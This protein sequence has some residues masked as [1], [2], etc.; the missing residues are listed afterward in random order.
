MN[1]VTMFPEAQ[2]IHLTKDVGMI[3]YI[4][5]K[6]YNYNST[7]VCYK[8]EET[9]NY[10]NTEVKGLKL[11]YLDKVTG[12]STKDGLIYLFKNAKKIDVLHTFHL[13][14]RSLCWIYAYKLLNSKG[15][16]YL[17]LDANYKIRDY[18]YNKND[19]KSIIKRHILRKTDLISVEAKSFYNFINSNWATKVEFI[20]NGIYSNGERQE[21]SFDSK[22]NIILTVGRI[23]TYEKANEILLQGFKLASDKLN[24]WKLKVV[25]PI[26]DKFNDYI[27]NFLNENPTL[28]E[29]IIFTGAIYDKEK[30][31][32]E[33]KKAKVFCLTSRYEGF[34]LV[35]L[36]AIK[37]GCY[38]IS[39]N[40][41][42]AYDIT[43]NENYGYLFSIDDINQL[44]EK[45][46]KACTNE[47][48]L[49]KKC[50]QIQDYAYNNFYWPTLC[51][52]IDRELKNN[53][54]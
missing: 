1:F 5:F 16:V 29:K 27:N 3:P 25:G 14:S 11:N 46:I 45:L 21:V 41:D 8:N 19:L 52:K 44:S 48:N 20:P 37:N 7:L 51:A 33:Y 9:Y 24:D 4:L 40:F 17:K 26:E 30:L 34:P 28:R 15:K 39:T 2:N 36:E 38:I 35:L 12:N 47:A 42:S 6:Y 22:E 53:K 18:D 43:N 54:V 31:E 50:V 32:N 10:L 13:S 23:G 49:E